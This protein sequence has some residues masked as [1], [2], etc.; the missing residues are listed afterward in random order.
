MLDIHLNYLMNN[1]IC[2][3]CMIF[4]EEYIEKFISPSLFFLTIE[5]KKKERKK[6]LTLLLCICKGSQKFHLNSKYIMLKNI[7]SHN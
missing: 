1:H 5:K 7:D 4:E 2:Y 6:D 3:I